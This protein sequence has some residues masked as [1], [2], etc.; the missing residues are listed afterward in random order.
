MSNQFEREFRRAWRLKEADVNH[1]H[2]LRAKAAASGL[3]L[4]VLFFG[5]PLCVAAALVAAV[6]VYNSGTGLDGQLRIVN[7]ELRM[8]QAVRDR[9][10]ATGI[11]PFEL[12][13]KIEALRERRD[14]L[15]EQ[16]REELDGGA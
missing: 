8:L 7:S 1:G 9:A 13:R 15:R 11:V 16:K 4:V 3:R 5:V 14:E 2:E 12:D 6:A 10:A